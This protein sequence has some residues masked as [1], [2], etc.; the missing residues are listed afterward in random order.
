MSLP[1]LANL[2]AVRRDAPGG[3]DAL[4][5]RLREDGRFA[6][7]LRPA[8][9]WVVG[10]APLPHGTPDPPGVRSA[11]L[12]FAEGRDAVGDPER[13][14]RLGRERPEGLGELPGDFT[15]LAFAGDGSVTA[16]R[17]AGGLAPLYVADEG[18]VLATRLR[19][20]L[21]YLAAV[22]LDP[23]PNAI[24][25]TGTPL[26]PEGRTFLRGVRM[27]DRGSF[28]RVPSQAGA[29]R[30]G[31]YWDPRPDRLRPPSE[32][33]L[34]EHAGRLRAALLERLDAD[35]DPGG[36]NLL[37]YSGGIDSSSLLG[38]AGG[39][40]GRPVS[41][42]SLIPTGGPALE[43]ELA[44]LESG[45]ERAR[46][47]HHVQIPMSAADRSDWVRDSV[48]PGFH[49]PHP[50]LNRL[51][52][53]MRETDVRVVFGGEF[54]D[55]VGG[56]KYTLPD[57][58]ALTPA[59]RLLNLRRLPRGP[60]DWV[61][62]ARTRFSR[63]SIPYPSELPAWMHPDVRAEYEAWL[64]GVARRSAA[65]RRSLAHLDLRAG[66]DGFTAMNWEACSELGL[67]R[68]IPFFTRAALEVAYDCH[69]GELIG[70]GFRR[71][72]R[73]A[74]ARDVPA[75]NLLRDDPGR[76]DVPDS[77]PEP[78]EG[79]LPPATG[80][81]LDASWHPRPPGPVDALTGLFLWQLVRFAQSVGLGAGGDTGKSPKTTGIDTAGGRP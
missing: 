39:T 74:L 53:V 28:A 71:L 20:T 66:M 54:G 51:A 67:R 34:R 57:W 77:A 18:R 8:P 59:S 43:R 33:R 32:D 13:A 44:Y 31:V 6:E 62:W 41:A 7:V 46:L 23:L 80:S 56:S 81:I 63:S 1:P 11:G 2:L 69:P 61:R 27:L 49:V 47:V 12:V 65:D 70:P 21:P 25:M 10:I 73:A 24:W 48:S 30:T 17:S 79:T 14:A 45:Q 37:T 5:R 29:V 35:L 36:G 9:G 4:E 3:T 75:S 16:V 58:A 76:W 15:F 68:S 64:G 78:W 55:E 38:L 40:L 22:E 19:W 50:A 42:L 52:E 72:T 60:R 26:F